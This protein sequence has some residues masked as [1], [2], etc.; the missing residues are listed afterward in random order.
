MKAKIKFLMGN[1]DE[2]IFNVE[3]DTQAEIYK[4][5]V[6]KLNKVLQREYGNRKQPS[7][8]FHEI[9]SFHI[10]PKDD[11]PGDKA[12]NIAVR[13]P[14]QKLRFDLLPFGPLTEVVK[15]LTFGAYNYGDRNWEAG[16]S[17]SR[18]IGSTFRHFI[19]WCLGEDKDD[20]SGLNHLAH[21]IANLLFLLQYTIT[22]KG[23]DDR[24]KMPLDKITDLFYPINAEIIKRK[25]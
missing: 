10:F 5:G 15:V 20:E 22:N 1:R 3:A 9:D 18:C 4:K 2:Y 13:S 19:K 17:W 14:L 7:N 16:F 12:D 11:V 6:T 25:E 24:Q 23:V 8:R 21:T